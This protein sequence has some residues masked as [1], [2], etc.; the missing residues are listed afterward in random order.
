MHG[1]MLARVRGHDKKE[2]NIIEFIDI[3]DR[4]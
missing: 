1:K 4:K 2:G 3:Q